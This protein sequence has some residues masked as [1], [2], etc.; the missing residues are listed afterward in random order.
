M[1]R[2][3]LV[4]AIAAAAACGDDLR[5]SVDGGSDDAPGDAFSGDLFGEPCT[6]VPDVVASCH[7]G[8]GVCHD[9]F[10]AGVCRPWSCY[11][12]GS[13]CME[14]EDQCP[15]RGGIKTLEHGVYFCMPRP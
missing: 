14:G 7:G 9:E 1:K 6:L 5:E 2:T 4:V 13:Y 15:G 8:A 11:H 12:P 3:V 10:G